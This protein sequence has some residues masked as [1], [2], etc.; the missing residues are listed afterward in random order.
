MQ[1]RLIEGDLWVHVFEEATF[2]GRLRILVA[3][4]SAVVGKIGSLVVGPAA[5]LQILDSNDREI[6]SLPSKTLIDDFSKLLARRRVS[7]IRVTRADGSI[8]SRS[9]S[10]SAENSLYS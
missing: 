7:R 10:K 5:M 9:A 2:G 1:K 6:M 8:A 3:D 4:E